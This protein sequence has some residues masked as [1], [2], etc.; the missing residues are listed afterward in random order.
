M[1][2]IMSRATDLVA[3]LHKARV[4]R[5]K[6]EASMEAAMKRLKDEFDL[7]TVAAA[8]ERLKELEEDIAGNK[9][10]EGVLDTKLDR[11]EKEAFGDSR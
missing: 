5:A 8:R 3:R 4:D 2:N 11:I 10:Q 7:D 9:Q 1:S 6:A